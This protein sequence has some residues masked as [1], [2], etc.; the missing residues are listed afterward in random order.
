M[1]EHMRSGSAIPVGIYEKALPADVSWEERLGL[2]A[3]AG[4]NFVGNSV[5]ES[6]ARLARLPWPLC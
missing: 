5:D 2:A 1:V 3:Q 6:E 4:D